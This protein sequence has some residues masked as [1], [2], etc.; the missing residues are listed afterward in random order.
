[1]NDPVNHPRHY[2]MGD[3]ETIE[4]V[5]QVC[6][7]YFGD[8]AF[9]VGSALRY[10]ARAPHK[11]NKLEDL[12]K[13]VWYLQ[14]AIGRIESKEQV[15]QEARQLAAEEEEEEKETEPY[16]APAVNPVPKLR[17]RG[18]KKGRGRR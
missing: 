15:Y 13:A 8:E 14:H 6:A 17:G 2:N 7:H 5:D 11:N 18:R 16:S 4:F 1:M 12:Q 9:S 10:L 3:I